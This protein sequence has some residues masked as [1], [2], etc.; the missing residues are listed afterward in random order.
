M[1]VTKRRMEKDVISFKILDTEVKV[2]MVK[3]SGDLLQDKVVTLT[4]TRAVGVLHLWVVQ[5]ALLL[6]DLM[7]DSVTMDSEDIMM[8]LVMILMDTTTRA[9]TIMV[10]THMG[11]TLMDMIHMAMMT[12]EDSGETINGDHQA[13][14]VTDLPEGSVLLQA[15]GLLDSVL[16]ASDLRVAMING[17][18]VVMM[19]SGDP[20][21]ETSGDSKAATNGDLLVAIS[22]DLP[23]AISGVHQADQVDSDHP[24]DLV[25]SGLLDHGDHLVVLVIGVVTIALEVAR[26]PRVHHPKTIMQ[27]WTTIL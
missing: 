8:T 23:A 5:V 20:L 11:T 15:L 12:K 9:T 24:E 17:D 26:A 10:M 18:M 6:S 25:D 14:Q 3:I 1:T 22:G 16:Q 2:T 27:T 21:A 7:E 13:V 4:V 19:T